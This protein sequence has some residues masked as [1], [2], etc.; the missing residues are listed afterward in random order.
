M[1]R[2]C[3]SLQDFKGNAHRTEGDMRSPRDRLNKVLLTLNF[4]NVN[5]QN[6]TAAERHCIV[7]RTAVEL[8]HHFLKIF[9]VFKK[10]LHFHYPNS[11]FKM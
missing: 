1:S 7:E 8:K 11:I 2:N 4:L 10:S 3:S 5:E 9:L 6:T